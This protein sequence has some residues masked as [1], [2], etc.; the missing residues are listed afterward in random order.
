MIPAGMR[1]E[2]VMHRDHV[3]CL[4]SD[5]SF[6]SLQQW[7]GCGRYPG[8]HLLY[9]NLC[10]DSRDAGLGGQAEDD[11]HGTP[12]VGHVAAGCKSCRW[13]VGDR[14]EAGV[15]SPRYKFDFVTL[16]DSDYKT[17]GGAVWAGGGERDPTE[18]SGE[19]QVQTRS[20]GASRLSHRGAGGEGLQDISTNMAKCMGSTVGR[21]FCLFHWSDSSSSIS[22]LLVCWL[23]LQVLEVWSSCSGDTCW[24]ET[25]ES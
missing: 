13:S 12:Q 25:I 1:T 6:C 9:R 2:H 3:P 24:F 7:V 16:Q 23:G 11:C 22:V 4:L 19:I 8:G 10:S 14:A 21:S 5:E 17:A 20:Q 15:F 18:T